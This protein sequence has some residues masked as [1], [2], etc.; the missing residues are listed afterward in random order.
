MHV[1][2]VHGGSTGS[3]TL[4][5]ISSLSNFQRKNALPKSPRDARGAPSVED[6]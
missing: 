1:V 3:T 6:G 4:T 2:S 5:V